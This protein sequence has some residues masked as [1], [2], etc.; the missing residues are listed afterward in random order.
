MES[1]VQAITQIRHRGQRRGHRHGEARCAAPLTAAEQPQG[2]IG[3][4]RLLMRVRRHLQRWYEGERP[5]RR[6]LVPEWRAL[7]PERLNQATIVQSREAKALHPIIPGGVVDLTAL[8]AVAAR[9][10]WVTPTLASRKILLMLSRDAQDE[11]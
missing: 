4:G 3:E 11:I 6:R 1:E 7:R 9:A 2:C 8:A 5:E 10:P